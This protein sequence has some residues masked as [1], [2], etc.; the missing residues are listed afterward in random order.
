MALDFP[1]SPTDGDEY[2]NFVWSD[3]RGAWE[4]KPLTSAKAAVSATAPLLPNQGDEWFNTVDGNL[5]VYYND[6]DTS[7]WVQVKSDAT[8]SSTLGNRVT[9]LESYPSGLVPI[10]PGS[11]TV[12]SGSATVSENGFITF[13]GT[14]SISLNSIFSSKFENYKIIWKSNGTTDSGTSM[15]FRTTG[16]DNTTAVYNFHLAYWGATGVGNIITSNA[17]TIGGI[18]GHAYQNADI[19]IFRPNLAEHTGLTWYGVARSTV[20][21]TEQHTS[22]AIFKNTTVFDGITFYPGSGTQ[23]GTLQVYGY[24]K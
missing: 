23:S 1:A 3:T 11:I 6:G 2:G 5:Y 16:T 10:I 9:T 19:Q 13:S 7:Q 14:S 17:S 15:R 21:N 8:L 18:F 12:G 22:S 4:A 24:R 20:N